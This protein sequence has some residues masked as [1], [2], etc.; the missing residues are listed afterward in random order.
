MKIGKQKGTK[1]AAR[2]ADLIVQAKPVRIVFESEQQFLRLLGAS[3]PTSAG[4]R[5]V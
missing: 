2:L 5:R 4:N 3:S 1:E